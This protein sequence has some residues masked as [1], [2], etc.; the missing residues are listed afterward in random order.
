MFALGTMPAA[1]GTPPGF[2]PGG[3]CPVPLAGV[4]VVGA[5]AFAPL[6]D[7]S[8]AIS[9]LPFGFPGRTVRTRRA[10][11]RC[12]RVI[13]VGICCL[14]VT[15]SLSRRCR[16]RLCRRGRSARGIRSSCFGRNWSRWTD[17]CRRRIH[18]GILWLRRCTRL[19]TG[20]R[21][22]LR[23][24]RSRRGR[25]CRT[26][27]RSRRCGRLRRLRRRSGGSGSLSRGPVCAGQSDC[28]R[29]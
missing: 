22:T 4:L 3:F 2:V 10:Y 23:G 7:G 11:T 9:V 26:G 25:L 5:F 8:P 13:H 16:R 27:G 1:Q 6:A 21:H 19:R 29:N 14:C 17:C 28:E 20:G 12:S 15:R 24:S 18:R